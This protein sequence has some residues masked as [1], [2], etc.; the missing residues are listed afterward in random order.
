MGPDGSKWGQEDFFLPIQTL[1]T[2][3][4]ETDFDFEDFCFS[5]NRACGVGVLTDLVKGP[6]TLREAGDRPL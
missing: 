2:F 4:G 5:P 1:P 6:C 3:L